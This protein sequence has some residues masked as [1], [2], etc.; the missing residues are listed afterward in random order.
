MI[1]DFLTQVSTA[2]VLGTGASLSTSSIPLGVATKNDEVEF[3]VNV[4]GVSGTTPTL[5]IEVIG[6]DDAALTSNVIS[7]GRFDP[8]I[9]A[10]MVAENFYVKASGL[11]KKAFLGLRYTMAGTTPAATV[12]SGTASAKDAGYHRAG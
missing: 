7:L 11:N 8:V 12:T 9:A 5:A 4:S 6:A 1:L 2:Q 10:S 3:L